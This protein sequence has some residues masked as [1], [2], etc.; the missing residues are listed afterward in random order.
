[1]F[2]TIQALFVIGVLSMVTSTST[3][4][5]SID[6][7]TYGNIDEIRTQHLALDLEI[8]FDNKTFKGTATHTMMFQGDDFV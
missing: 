5:N 8:N 4:G 1:M 3:I 7:S 6:S 2:K